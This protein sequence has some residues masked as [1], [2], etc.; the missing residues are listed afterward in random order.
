MFKKKLSWLYRVLIIALIF[1]VIIFD[2]FAKIWV[3]RGGIFNWNDLFDLGYYLNYGTA[4]GILIP[5]VLLFPL[6]FIS[7]VLIIWKYFKFIR[8]GYMWAYLAIFMI[9]GGAL[10]N[11]ADRII[12]GFVI[13]YIHFW[14]GSTFNLADVLIV[15][16]VG[17]LILKELKK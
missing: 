15:F 2:Q 4:F 3:K 14:F 6:I 17:V 5:Y 1:A 10:S 9:I 11:V 12:H 13:D 8:E 7:L 16:G